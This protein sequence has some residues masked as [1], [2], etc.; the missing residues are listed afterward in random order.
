M[1]RMAGMTDQAQAGEIVCTDVVRLLVAGKSYLFGEREP[2]TL[3]GVEE[4]VRLFT[5]T[6]RK[7][8]VLP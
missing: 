8:G 3:K 1:T 7:R 6:L 2:A 4:P 5:V